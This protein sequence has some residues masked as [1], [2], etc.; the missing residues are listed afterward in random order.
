MTKSKTKIE[1]QL[2]RKKNQELVETIIK[3]KKSDK[4]IEV[5]EAL[6]CPRRKRAEIN[7]EEINKKAKEGEIILV[8]GKVLSQGEL[9]K[10]IKIAAL[11]FSENAKEKI[12]K[13]GAT[14]LSIFELIEENPE[15]KKVK[16]LK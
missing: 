11:N 2:R 5:A 15:I 16:I 8:P 7:L 12:A 9:E 14:F 3:A 4:W 1:E 10:K 6:S 13:A